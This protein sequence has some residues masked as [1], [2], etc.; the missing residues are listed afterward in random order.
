AAGNIPRLNHGTAIAT[1]S[2]FGWLG[3]VVGPPVIGHLAAATSLPV[4]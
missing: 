3:F 4:A 1:V 2:A